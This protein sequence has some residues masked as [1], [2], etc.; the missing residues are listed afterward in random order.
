MATTNHQPHV[1]ISRTD[2]ERQKLLS[3][4]TQ[5]GLGGYS[6]S[7]Q[8]RNRSSEISA[9]GQAIKATG[10]PRHCSRSV[11]EGS[12]SLIS[13]LNTD[14]FTSHRLT[15]GSEPSTETE[16]L[17]AFIQRRFLPVKTQHLSHY[18]RLSFTT[19]MLREC[20]TTQTSFGSSQILLLPLLASV[21]P[22][23][24]MVVRIE[25]LPS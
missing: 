23:I 13:A 12:R 2:R 19:T 18:L 10:K 7:V 1:G 5:G 25:Y 6:A 4:G 22:T 24:A 14:G 17:E 20:G 16:E 15:A 11:A 21:L 8:V 9:G 3:A